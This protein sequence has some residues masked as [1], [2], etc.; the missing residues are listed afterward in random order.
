MTWY[1]VYAIESGD[2][3]S[4]TDDPTKVAAPSVLTA[5]GYAVAECPDGAQSGV[6]NVVTHVFDPEPPI[7]NSYPTW[8]WLSR[9]TAAELATIRASSD[10]NVAA[11]LFRLQFTQMIEPTSADIQQGLAYL[12]SIGLLT[13][14]RVAT[15]GAN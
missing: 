4:G 5:R 3:I 2:L 14:D 12:Q 9:F 10:E 15:I 11:L 13:P 1:A 8:K 6:W 7:I